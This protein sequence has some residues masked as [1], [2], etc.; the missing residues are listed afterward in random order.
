MSDKN[1]TAVRS[2]EPVA[3]PGVTGISKLVRSE[4]GKIHP[5]LA[6]KIEEHV[7]RKG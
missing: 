5:E 1:P 3:E 7:D 2:S 6:R 4:L